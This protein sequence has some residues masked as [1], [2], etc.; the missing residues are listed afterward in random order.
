MPPPSLLQR[1]KERKLV[2]RLISASSA[3]LVLASLSY[4]PALSQ[5]VELGLHTGVGKWTGEGSEGREVGFPIGGHLLYCEGKARVGIGIDH[6]RYGE[7]GFEEKTK[8]LGVLVMFRYVFPG[9]T[10]QFF[11]G[12]KVGYERLTTKDDWLGYD[13]VSGTGAG[14][15]IGVQIPLSSLALEIT[16]EVL[17]V[18]FEGFGATGEPIP[19]SDFSALQWAGRLGIA[20]P[21]GR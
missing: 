13:F 21:I 6:A 19:A 15:A 20:V 9:E 14:P 10:A 8:A 11:V 2:G 5:S 4:A 1:L 17:Y 18:S 3:A 7:E 12:A 16:G